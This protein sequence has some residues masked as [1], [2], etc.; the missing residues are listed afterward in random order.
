[1]IKFKTII[2]N[3]ILA[4]SIITFYSCFSSGNKITLREVE[5]NSDTTPVN[6]NHV[7]SL[8]FYCNSDSLIVSFD[9]IFKVEKDL[10]LFRCLLKNAYDGD[11]QSQDQLML[12]F[13]NLDFVEMT[14]LTLSRNHLRGEKIFRKLLEVSKD[15]FNE[16]PNPRF[17]RLMICEHSLYARFYSEMILKIK[18]KSVQDFKFENFHSTAL[19]QWKQANL[20][21]E[22]NTICDKR[23][24]WY[25]LIRMAYK[26]DL[27]EFKKYGE[28]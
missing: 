9:E 20:P 7:D 4:S 11:L 17:R 12:L 13:S 26:N 16:I 2:L 5:G 27:I 8:L 19:N 14:N 28:Q 21:S 18:G 6:T 25:E 10:S 3:T 22:S 15:K 1:M 24:Y 23:I